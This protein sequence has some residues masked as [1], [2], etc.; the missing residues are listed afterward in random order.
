[1]TE[2][3]P[4]NL[5]KK[6]KIEEIDISG[7]KKKFGKYTRINQWYYLNNYTGEIC[8]YWW[9][10][11]RYN[12]RA[13]VNSYT[14]NTHAHKDVLGNSIHMGDKIITISST[15][16]KSR[17]GGTVYTNNEWTTGLVTGATPCFV[18]TDYRFKSLPRRVFD[19]TALLCRPNAYRDNFIK[20]YKLDHPTKEVDN[21]EF[22][23]ER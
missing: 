9:S 19:L 2:K 16:Q 14:N 10:K 21:Y 1:V 22:E 15:R 18:I 4:K 13:L 23:A 7:I 12:R 17:K 5:G 6:P 3:I 8:E 20:Q 11:W